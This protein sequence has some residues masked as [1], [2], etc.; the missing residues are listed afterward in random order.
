M[1][2]ISPH[3]IESAYACIDGQFIDEIEHVL[4]VLRELENPEKHE[5]RIFFMTKKEFK[6]KQLDMARNELLTGNVF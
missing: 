2:D 4:E 6:E 5:I 1:K 3:C